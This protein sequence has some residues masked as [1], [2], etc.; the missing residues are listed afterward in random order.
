MQTTQRQSGCRVVPEAI[1][2]LPVP[3]EKHFPVMLQTE[4]VLLLINSFFTDIITVN[5]K[6]QI[7]RKRY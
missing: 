2:F 6:I 1:L 7:L 5:R 4:P 3:P